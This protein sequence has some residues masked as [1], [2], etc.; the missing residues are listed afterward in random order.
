MTCPVCGHTMPDVTEG[1]HK[2][3]ADEGAEYL[4]DYVTIWLCDH[5]QTVAGSE[6]D[7]IEWVLQPQ[8]VGTEEE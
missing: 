5:C 1:W 3:V 6:G 7:E 8:E 2:V 4:S